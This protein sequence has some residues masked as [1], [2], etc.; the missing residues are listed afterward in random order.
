MASTSQ[1]YLKDKEGNIFS[2]VVSSQSVYWRGAQLI[3]K[4]S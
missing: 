4:K 3:Y 2:P 1:Q